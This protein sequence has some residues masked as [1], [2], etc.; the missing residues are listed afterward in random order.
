MATRVYSIITSSS[1]AA[2]NLDKYLIEMQM[3]IL[4]P[5]AGNGSARV[6]SSG[7]NEERGKDGLLMIHNHLRLS[8]PQGRA[9][10]Y[11]CFARYSVMKSN[12]LPILPTA[13]PG[14][15]RGI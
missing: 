13:Q 3:P 2:V 6:R 8:V 5:N 14:R 7:S 1:P 15:C 4:A 9:T 11:R 10:P 12:I